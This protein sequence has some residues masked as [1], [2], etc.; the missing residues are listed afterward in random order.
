MANIKRKFHSEKNSS[1]KNEER[2][3][4][5]GNTLFQTFR[6]NNEMKCWYGF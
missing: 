3:I 4:K 2:E 1:K 6:Q 5:G